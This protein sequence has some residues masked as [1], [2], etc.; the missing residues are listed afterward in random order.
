[1]SPSPHLKTEKNSV[2]Q[3]VM[4]SRNLEIRTMDK[5]HN[6]SDSDHQNPLDSTGSLR[7]HRVLKC[8]SLKL[9]GR[10]FDVISRVELS[11]C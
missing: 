2:S 6:P 7:G 1:V 5:V 4:F 11:F 10:H 9:Q 3:K 8:S